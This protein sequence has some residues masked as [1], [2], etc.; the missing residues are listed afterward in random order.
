VGASGDQLVRTLLAQFPDN[1]VNVVVAGNVRLVGQIEEVVRQARETGG[2][3]VHTLVDEALRDTL[4]A[5]AAQEHVQTFDLAGPLLAWL[6]GTLGKDSLAQPGLYRKLH[7]EYFERVAAIEYSMAHDDGKDPAGWHA[8]EIVLAG[9]SRTGKTP[10]S[11]YLSVL[12]WKVANVPIIP[13]VRVS[14]ELYRIDQRRV[15]GLTIEPG[16]L[17][18]HRQQRQ[19]R[20]GAPGFSAYV[21]PA[22]VFEEVQDAEKEFR[23]RGFAIVD[24][25]DKTIE[26]SAE[27]I[28]RLVTRQVK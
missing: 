21:D 10:L 1:H 2:L 5:M 12:G 7:K 27:E 20:L 23:E 18:I 13:G 9:V 15:I 26:T 11:L 8:A 28:I 4:A 17:L 14:Q 19:T 22:A 24:V 6:S 25:T 3:I 16:Q